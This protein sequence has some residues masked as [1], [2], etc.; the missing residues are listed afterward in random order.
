MDTGSCSA[1]VVPYVYILVSIVL[2]CKIP[3][4]CKELF[5]HKLKLYRKTE[6]FRNCSTKG[7]YYSEAEMKK[8]VSEGGLAYKESFGQI[9]STR[10]D[11]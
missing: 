3:H 5:N 9:D 2:I 8:P 6:Q 7:G 4:I 10:P 11:W 1:D